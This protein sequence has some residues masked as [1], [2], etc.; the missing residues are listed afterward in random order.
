MARRRSVVYLASALALVAGAAVAGPSTAAPP[1]PDG[2]YVAPYTGFAG[3][4]SSLRCEAG[5]TCRADGSASSLSGKGT[6]TSTFDRTAP[7]GGRESAFGYALQSF[8]VKTR[9]GTSSVSATFSWVVESSSV[10][11][12]ATS[13]LVQAYTGVA[14]FAGNCD[15][16]CTSETEAASV[17]YAGSSAGVPSTGMQPPATAVS[18]TVTA[19]GKLPR[20]LTFYGYPYSVAAGDV[21]QVCLPEQPE[22]TVLDEEHAG[23]AKA[24]ITAALSSVTV[25][26]S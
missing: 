2:T 17:E 15:G 9:P 18:V 11:A 16:G 3:F 10:E 14:A 8:T 5:A 6:T 19:T 4:G 13:G 20:H 1:T 26:S 23:S 25:T 22:C 21:S 24:S 12:T 7:V